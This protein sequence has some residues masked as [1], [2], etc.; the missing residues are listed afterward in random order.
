MYNNKILIVD[1][2][3]AVLTALKRSFI[4]LNHE[5][6]FM[7]SAKKALES[8]NQNKTAVLITDMKMPE[9][10]GV[11]LIIEA[12][13]LDPDIIGII[14][15]GYSEKITP[16]N[17][18]IIWKFIS[19]PWDTDNLISAINEAIILYNNAKGNVIP[20]I[21]EESSEPIT[22]KEL[23]FT[24]KIFKTSQSSSLKSII[25]VDDDQHMLKAINRILMDEP[26]M[27]YFCSS[28]K[29]TLDLLKQ[30]EPSIIIA[31]EKMD[32]M[33]GSELLFKAKQTYPNI[34]TILTTGESEIEVENK[35]K[36]CRIDAFIP[37]PWNKNKFKETL[38]SI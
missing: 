15:T 36:Q 23:T 8:L 34:K 27:L 31:D 9:I 10:N 6:I 24:Q 38:E 7:T 30:I 20:K 14:L 35:I 1:D 25:L 16:Q 29:E 5:F 32:D 2:E 3:K 18:N 22:Q 12:K 17:Q 37:K 28:A 19:K 33:S 21:K 13:K 11:D 4:D 26:Y